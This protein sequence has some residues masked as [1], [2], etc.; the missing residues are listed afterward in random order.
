LTAPI[1]SPT[2]ADVPESARLLVSASILFAALGFACGDDS[3]GEPESATCPAEA[4]ARLWASPPGQQPQLNGHLQDMVMVGDRLL[5]RWGPDIPVWR[6]YSADLCG[7]E[8]VALDPT[9]DLVDRFMMSGSDELGSVL[10]GYRKADRAVVQLDRLEVEG[11]DE[12]AEVGSFGDEELEW[13]H[14]GAASMYFMTSL[15]PDLVPFPAAGVGGKPFSMW[16]HAG[17]PQHPLEPLPGQFVHIAFAGAYEPP[18]GAGP[19]LT[20]T[21]AGD[22]RVY[23][24]AGEQVAA[25]PQV[26][27]GQRAPGGTRLVWQQIGDDASEPT[28]VRDLATGVDI[29]LTANAHTAVSWGRLDLAQRGTGMWMWVDDDYLGLVGPDDDLVAVHDAVTGEALTVPDHVMVHSSSPEGFWLQLP[30]QTQE[31]VAALWNP[32]DGELFEYYRQ[33]AHLRFLRLPMI[34]GDAWHYLLLDQ[35]TSNRGSFW[36]IDRETGAWTKLLPTLGVPFVELDDGRF[37][38]AL[39][40]EEGRYTR[41]SVVEPETAVYTTLA[42]GVPREFAYSP[43]H[44]V[45]WLRTQGE[46]LGLWTAPIPEAPARSR[47]GRA[48]GWR[49]GGRP[50]G[51][52]DPYHHTV[53]DVTGAA[54]R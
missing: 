17:D 32:R 6:M 47:S 5:F 36:R 34:D 49:D 31:T 50:F 54:L 15:Q 29:E 23:D 44:G 38:T 37:V 12:P 3:T 40:D 35:N 51:A 20:L 43:A 42:E 52:A 24:L 27:Y 39:E 46:A 16:L 8:V 13:W 41:L 28:F 33:P 22:L 9:D 19:V 14:P 4:P 48:A 53:A 45:Y 2:L 7:D 30:S 26:R 25:I 11:L 10:F 18:R 1:C 21:D